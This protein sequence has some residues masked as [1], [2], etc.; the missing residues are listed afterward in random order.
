MQSLLLERFQAPSEA[1]IHFSVIGMYDIRRVRN[2]K[3]LVDCVK[4]DF[5]TI[6]DIK[7]VFGYVAARSLVGAYVLNLNEIGNINRMTKEQTDELSELLTEEIGYF[8]ITELHEFFKRIK[9]SYY[10]NYYGSFDVIKIMSDLRLFL[11]DRRQTA[12]RVKQLLQKEKFDR[13]FCLSLQNE[14]PMPESLKMIMNSN[15]LKIR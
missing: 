3:T 11:N 5:P 1:L 13:E 10:G 9:K 15:R 14:A 7:E 2:I 4:C 8:K 12:A 6:L